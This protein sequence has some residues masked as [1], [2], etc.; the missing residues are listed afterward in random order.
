MPDLRQAARRGRLPRSKRLKGLPLLA[1][2][3]AH[4]KQAQPPDVKLP[5][6]EPATGHEKN[7]GRGADYCIRVRQGGVGKKSRCCDLACALAAEGRRVGNAGRRCLRTPSQPRM[8]GCFR[9]A[10]VA[11]GKTSCRMRNFGVTQ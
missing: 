7:S 3:R 1:V 6:I 8:P 2:L 9:T 4:S 10:C 11:D 5:Q